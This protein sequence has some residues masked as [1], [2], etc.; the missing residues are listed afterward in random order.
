M[1][2]TGL[3]FSLFIISIITLL[4][5]SCSP[6]SKPKPNDSQ[7][8]TIKAPSKTASINIDSL[9]A[10][11]DTNSY[12]NKSRDEEDNEDID[13]EEEDDDYELDDV[14]SEDG[15][16]D[17][18]FPQK[19]RHATVTYYED[20]GWGVKRRYNVDVDVDVQSGRVTRVHFPDNGVYP[21][22]TDLT[23]GYVENGHTHVTTDYGVGYDIEIH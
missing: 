19:T 12:T 9:A 15:Y 2:K 8:D 16:E 5:C 13:E 23:G 22:G 6:W 1:T 14:Y 4:I 3:H 11:I 7:L 10:T 21:S 17:D 18:L 20:A